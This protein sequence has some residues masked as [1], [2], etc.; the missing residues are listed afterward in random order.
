MKYWI[1]NVGFDIYE[2]PHNIVGANAVNAIVAHHKLK[3]PMIS[4]HQSDLSK[5]DDAELPLNSTLF[6]YVFKPT[7]KIKID[8]KDTKERITDEYRSLLQRH[9]KLVGDFYYQYFSNYLPTD[10]ERNSILD[11]QRDAGAKVLSD[12]ETNP[13]QSVDQ[14]ES[15]ILELRNNNRK[16]ITSPT[17]DMGMATIGLFGQ[18]IDMLLKHKFQRFNVI[19]RPILTYQFNWIELS[20]KLLQKPIWC[21]VVGIPQRFLSSVNPISLLSIPF[22]YGVHSTSL[23]YPTRG[24]KKKNSKPK[25]KLKQKYSFNNSTYHFE[26][27]N[28]N[29]S[30][31]EDRVISFND[32]IDEL[33]TARNHII[34]KTFYSKYV[35][36][37]SGLLQALNELA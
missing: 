10:I 22:L 25:P 23:G 30:A 33:E 18:K 4:P 32:Q 8:E 36:S 37:K 3:F 11:V 6:Q 21:N 31:L 14:L 1:K 35:R 7:R 12:Y 19:Y 5:S 29:N 24:R 2:S 9:S 15:Q 16:Y 34:K 17:L 20:K 27:S 26:I 13:E 28:N